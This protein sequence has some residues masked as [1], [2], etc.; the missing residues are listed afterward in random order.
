MFVQLLSTD[1]SSA[2]DLL[3]CLEKVEGHTVHET[4]AARYSCFGCP[5]KTSGVV[6]VRYVGGKTCDDVL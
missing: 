2:E 3:E 1:E 5:L 4:S 6:Y